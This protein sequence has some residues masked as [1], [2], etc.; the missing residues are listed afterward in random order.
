[1]PPPPPPPVPVIIVPTVDIFQPRRNVTFEEREITV[2]ANLIGVANKRDI[3][4]ILNRNDCVDFRFNPTNGNF[5]AKVPLQEGKNE[6]IIKAVNPAG[7]DRQKVVV[8]HERPY[9]PII[10]VRQSDYTTTQT[11]SYTHLTLPT[12]PYV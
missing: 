7:V 12:T 3:E 2:K 6:I 1:M 5:R 11:V 9:A 10:E 4:F 8:Y